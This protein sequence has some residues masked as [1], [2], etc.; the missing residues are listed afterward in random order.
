[1]IIPFKYID[2]K[3]TCQVGGEYSSIPAW[4][5]VQSS[6]D[7]ADVQWR[8]KG[9]FGGFKPPSPEIPKFSQSWAKFPIQCKI[10]L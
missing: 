4:P 5:P 9:G 1:M 10:H 8:T 2:S 6:N 7:I 3:Y